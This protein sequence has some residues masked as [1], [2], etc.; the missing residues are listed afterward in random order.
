M[1]SRYFIH[2]VDDDLVSERH[3]F[4]SKNFLE[5]QSKNFN[6]KIIEL[7]VFDKNNVL[8]ASIPLAGKNGVW[9]SPITGAFSGF[10]LKKGVSISALEFLV[11]NLVKCM[12][13]NNE[14]VISITIKFPPSCF[15]DSSAL[16]SNILI[17]SEWT[18]SGFDINYHLD[19][20]TEA[21]FLK[22]LGETKRKT[23]K[24]L[25]RV[26]AKFK[27]DSIDELESIYKVISENRASQ[28]YPM[29]MPFSA[30]NDL[31]E[32]FEDKIKLFSVTLENK[33]VAG[34][35]CI[36]VNTD[37]L[38]VFYWG[39]LPEFRKSSPVM[40]LANGIVQF[41]ISNNIKTLDIGTASLDFIP[42]NGLAA[43]KS[44]IGCDVT[45]KL[46]FHLEI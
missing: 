36:V 19:I 13:D 24:R 26:G 30:L 14:N 17:R 3:F 35:I 4:N 21:D 29:T 41:C 2:L 22:K 16:M 34:A 6:K 46:T 15:S 10:L 9:K 20:T 27:V 33:I 45:S 5:Y 37:Y 31:T 44:S 43:F 1:E 12:T 7:G 18:L 8:L 39:E 23:I 42:N 25:D 11:K 28:G 32:N 38:Y 40:K